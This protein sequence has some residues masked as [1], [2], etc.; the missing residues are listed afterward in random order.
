M[1][2]NIYY[3][4]DEKYLKAVQ[5]M[6]FGNNSKAKLLLEEILED[7]PAY[8][9]AHYRLA[10]IYYFELQEYD[11]AIYHFD[12]TMRFTP[13]F[14]LLYV[15]Y[16]QLLNFLDRHEQLKSL[17]VKALQV[18]GVCKSCVMSELG[19]SYEKQQ[20]FKKA[21]K[22]FREAWLHAASGCDKEDIESH[23][24]RVNKKM[25]HLQPYR[26]EVK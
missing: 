26:Y 5:K 20:S 25:R 23:I 19:L 9:K 22:Y 7:E 8:G 21:G 15:H 24:E 2:N 4:I 13:S 10:C 3:T 1:M 11:R 17:A 18:E 12:L 14:P 6:D 16:L